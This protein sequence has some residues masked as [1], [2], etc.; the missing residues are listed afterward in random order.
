MSHAEDPAPWQFHYSAPARSRSKHVFQG[1]LNLAVVELG[2]GNAPESRV[3][4]GSIRIGELRR[5]EGVEELRPEL[6]AVLFVV[7]HVKQFDRRE[8]K[9]M[10]A[11]ADQGISRRIAVGQQA[12]RKSRG[13]EPEGGILR[14][15]RHLLA[16]LQV[17]PLPDA[18][19]VLAVK[20]F[21]DVE[22][23]AAR[24]RDNPVQRPPSRQS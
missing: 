6:E 19:V 15:N 21:Q 1:E 5:V 4:Q 3:S 23:T 17:G 11:R 2:A 10:G 8:V 16:G 7:W 9:R 20:A 22:R 14:A 12:G 13:V 18:V 24:Q